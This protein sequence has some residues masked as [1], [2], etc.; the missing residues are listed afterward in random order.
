MSYSTWNHFMLLIEHDILLI[1]VP[2]ALSKEEIV[3]GDIHRGVD[4]RKEY[5]FGKLDIQN[6]M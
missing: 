3:E 5:L 4:A 1:S 6:V 2:F